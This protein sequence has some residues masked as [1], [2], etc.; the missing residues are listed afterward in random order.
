MPADGF[1]PYY[2][3]LGI[4]P[5][6]QPPT[7]YRILG[8][9][10]L[11]A[12]RQVI[13]TAASRQALHLRQMA[14]GPQSVLAARLMKEIAAAKAVLLNPEAKATYDRSLSPAVE[15]PIEEIAAVAT[16]LRQAGQ[17]PRIRLQAA[18][19]P[20]APYGFDRRGVASD[21]VPQ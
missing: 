4:P 13:A 3:W 2:K 9:A 12:D 7:H 14:A 6:E 20:L 19:D 16:F 5:D 15:L 8:I 11:E 18:A 1:D 10:P 21:R 17:S